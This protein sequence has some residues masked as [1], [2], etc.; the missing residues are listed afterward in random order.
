MNIMTTLT[1]DEIVILLG[2]LEE[3]TDPYNA[4]VSPERFVE[5]FKLEE[6]L[7]RMKKEIVWIEN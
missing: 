4:S 7:N 5:L 6:K 1:Y 2:I 3:L